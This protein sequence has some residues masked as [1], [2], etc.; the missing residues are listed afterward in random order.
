MAFGWPLAARA[1]QADKVYR[2]GYLSLGS[3][4]AEATR[5]NAFRGACRARL[6]EGKNLVIETRWLEGGK[7]DQL[8]ELVAQLVDLKVDVIVTYATPGVSAA[9]RV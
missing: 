5:F 3:P 8:A 9:K 4:A 2:I 7:Y 1:Q 6:R